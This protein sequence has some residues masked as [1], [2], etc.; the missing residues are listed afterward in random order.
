[1]NKKITKILLVEDNE[2]DARII[3]TIL[4]ESEKEAFE[5]FHAK[6]LTEA[7]KKVDSQSFDIILLD[8]TLP[9]SYGLETFIWLHA[10]RPEMPIVILSGTD[11]EMLA[12]K[13]VRKGAQDYLVKGR[14]DN[15][16]LTHSIHYAIERKKAEDALRESERRYRLLAQNVTDV[17]WT[18]D[19]NFRYIYI[20]PSVN[21]LNG[22]EV[23]E[24]VARSFQE[25]LTP[26][27][28]D[29]AKKAIA[30]E[31]GAESSDVAKV[32]RAITL[33]LKHT[34]KDGTVVWAEDRMSI[35]RNPEGEPTGILG[36]TRDIS[37]RK[38][39]EKL[40][41]EF[42]STVSHELRTPLTSI[43]EGVSQVID[44][45]LGDTTQEQ[46]SIL[47][48]CLEDIDRLRQIIDE[49]LD[50]SKIEAGKV[51]LRRELVDIVELIKRAITGFQTLAKK[52]SIVLKSILPE[53]H[54]KI[55]IDP[56]KVTQVITN[57]LSNAY[58]FTYEGGKITMELKYNPGT[59]E[60]SVQDTGV[61]INP[62][63]LKKIF[64]KF[65][66]IDRIDGPGIKG[67]GLGLTISKGLV[68]MHNGHIWAESTE[69]EGS[70][71][72]FSLPKITSEKIFLD[73]VDAKIKELS[74]KKLKLSVIILAVDNFKKTIENL[75]MNELNYSI[76]LTRIKESIQKSLRHVADNVM[77]YKRG[78][79]VVLPDTDKDEISAVQNR[80]E[81]LLEDFL[82][83]MNLTDEIKMKFSCA[84]YPDDGLTAHELFKSSMGPYA[85]IREK[86]VLLIDDES[87][88]VELMKLKLE[89]K[90]YKE[91]LTCIDG[92]KGLQMA[93]EKKPDLIILDMNMPGINGYEVIGRLKTDS[94][95][96]KTPIIILT[97]YTVD[98]EKLGAFQKETIPIL[99]KPV[100]D[101]DL[102]ENMEKFLSREPEEGE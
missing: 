60:I 1:M 82:T 80:I 53:E 57:L 95:T 68:E 25:T 22:F 50:I 56:G 23:E 20:S 75:G 51:E 9:D 38:R 55:I 86:T 34:C 49:L 87:Y 78:L 74:G 46:Q 27:S 45:I 29:T 10:Q 30:E 54:I 2:I 43:R 85:S 93:R 97:G 8:L 65:V 101:Q 48:L 94:A 26:D 7:L 31:L 59:V 16:P 102:F 13:A 73:Y 83:E 69:G 96:S 36:V 19:L 33:D 42:V 76:I 62:E 17:I 67:T 98:S 24:A 100:N 89:S 40:K 14:L 6:S 61:G 3:R 15:N 4:N 99:T 12:T 70:R 41:D 44:G 66:Q 72:T 92:L 32:F 79:S 84:T 71:F 5:L 64:D 91:V 58:K 63:N 11:D 88:F 47:G 21:L 77:E 37:D 35:L 81:K 18:M 28:F 39:L 90:G 52:K